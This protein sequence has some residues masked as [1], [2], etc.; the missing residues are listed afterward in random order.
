MNLCEKRFPSESL[1]SS[2]LSDVSLW[3][4]SWVIIRNEAIFLKG[5]RDGT[6]LGEVVFFFFLFLNPRNVLQFLNSSE[7][8]EHSA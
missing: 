8:Q 6:L 2:Q 5:E 1:Y 3:D 4:H 7:R